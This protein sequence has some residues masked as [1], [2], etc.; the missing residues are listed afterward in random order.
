MSLID[1]LALGFSVAASPEGLFYCVIGVTLGMVV[2]VLPGL[3][4]MA[5][6]AM[7]MPITYHIEPAYAI[8]MLAGIYYGADFGG[9][10]ASIL[11]NLPGTAMS[12]ITALDGYPMAKK[13]QAGLALFLKAVASFVGSMIGCVLLAVFS[14]PLAAMALRFG[15]QEYFT[16]MLFGLVAAS[17]LSS[18]SPLRSLAMVC[19]GMT[20]GL[21]GI[22]L[23]SGNARFTFGY[24]VLYDGLSLVAV[25]IGLFGIPELI[26]NAGK[27]ADSTLTKEKISLK[28][29]LP[30]RAQWRRVLM[31]MPRSD[32]TET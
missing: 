15:P 3:G 30:D 10:T 11:L 16:L 12:A 22:D 24:P 14:A 23:N 20:L 28:S 2:G 17:M 7:L 5:T 9:S 13:G 18:G 1:N 25:A 31:P 27:T 8:I 4:V 19:F 26:A 32:P 6:L 29:M 21:V